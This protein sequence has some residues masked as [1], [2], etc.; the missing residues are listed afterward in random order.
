MV[1]Y[2]LA[3]NAGSLAGNIFLN[4]ALNAVVDVI[5]I[6]SVLLKKIR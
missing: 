1:F 6:S 5:W 4:N 3:L 2:G